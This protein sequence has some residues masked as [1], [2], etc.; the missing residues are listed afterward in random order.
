[1]Y[2]C[3]TFI[4]GTIRFKGF[5]YII[6]AF[7]DVGLTSDEPA[8][9]GVKTL[10]NLVDSLTANADINKCHPCIDEVLNQTVLGIEIGDSYFIKRF[11]AS[12]DV[13][14]IEEKQ[15][16]YAYKSIINAIRFFGLM[17]DPT[18]IKV[19][20]AQGKPLSYLDIFGN[21]MSEKLSMNENDIDLVVMRH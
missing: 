5:S 7:H 2:D 19:V 21:L 15:I 13:S 14:Y 8:P 17:D 20:N 16:K 6:S 12:V 11:L 9:T 4:R 1:M 18:P 10:R 3:E